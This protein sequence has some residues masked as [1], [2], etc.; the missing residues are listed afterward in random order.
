MI[1]FKY[2]FG[3]LKIIFFAFV[4]IIFRFRI[5]ISNRIYTF[6]NIYSDFLNMQIRYISFSNKYILTTR[7]FA[8]VLLE[9][10]LD[11][12]APLEQTFYRLSRDFKISDKLEAPKSS[13]FLVRPAR[14]KI[15]IKNLGDFSS[16]GPCFWNDFPR[17]FISFR[18]S[19]RLLGPGI[20][21]GW[22]SKIF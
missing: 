12:P 10:A 22:R 17:D 5:K 16:R 19:A 21:P 7:L 9:C 2:S 13:R 1:N 4:F 14:L 15:A 8:V 18:L 20:N 6:N 11:F 3:I